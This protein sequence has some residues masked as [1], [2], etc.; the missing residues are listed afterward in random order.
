MC[1]LCEN[2]SFSF[3]EYSSRYISSTPNPL[4]SIYAPFFPSC[5]LSW[6]PNEHQTA[7]SG[8][9]TIDTEW[10]QKRFSFFFFLSLPLWSKLLL[11]L[12]PESQGWAAVWEKIKQSSFF[13]FIP[14][15]C[16]LF[17]GSN[18]QETPHSSKS[19]DKTAALSHFSL[20]VVVWI[21]LQKR[22]LCLKIWIFVIIKQ[23]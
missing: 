18:I 23:Q 10:Q 4:I 21:Q 5:V 20:H 3:S 9:H 14:T 11:L 17:P 16:P 2:S 22:L 13:F 6:D 7:A 19:K 8:L 1:S 15:S 12:L